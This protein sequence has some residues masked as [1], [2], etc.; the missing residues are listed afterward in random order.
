LKERRE[1]RRGERDREREREREREPSEGTKE[2]GLEE[3]KEKKVKVRRNQGLTNS[4]PRSGHHGSP[5]PTAGT[6][7]SQNSHRIVTRM[8]K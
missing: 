3:G 2:L 6:P 7:K 4:V 1:R 8:E 5:H